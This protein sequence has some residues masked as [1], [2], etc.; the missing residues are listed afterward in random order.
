MNIDLFF[1]IIYYYLHVD[2]RYI[3]FIFIVA[4]VHTNI[5]VIPYIMF[6]SDMYEY[7]KCKHRILFCIIFHNNKGG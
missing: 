6:D 4:M 5:K 7:V 3:L 2:I 1:V